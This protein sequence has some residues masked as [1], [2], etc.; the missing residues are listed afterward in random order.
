LKIGPPCSAS[1]GRSRRSGS[2]CWSSDRSRLDRNRLN[3]A[4]TAHRTAG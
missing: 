1:L 4:T 2:N 3:P